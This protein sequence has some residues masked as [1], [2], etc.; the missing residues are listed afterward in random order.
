[1]ILHDHFQPSPPMPVDRASISTRIK[2]DPE[3]A[4][5]AT[6]DLLTLP[7]RFRSLVV[8][9]QNRVQRRQDRDVPVKVIHLESYGGIEL[10]VTRGVTWTVDKITF[11]P[12]KLVFGHN[13][14]ALTVEDFQKALSILL[15]Y[16]TVLLKDPAD[17]IHVIPG[18]SDDSGAWWSS[19]EIPFQVADPDGHLLQAFMNAKH[20]RIRKPALRCVGQ[21]ISWRSCTGDL[22]I[23]VYRKDIEMVA[24]KG[25]EGRGRRGRYRP[26]LADRG[27]PEGAG[28]A[29]R[30]PRTR[31]HQA[32][33]RCSE[34]GR[35]LLS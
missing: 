12:G 30:V 27:D 22:A 3:F 1:M 17:F 34:G 29:R 31:R 5:A 33:R 25:E 19:L 14:R 20:P 24:R 6:P 26:G 28:V 10:R 8:E 4:A 32:H 15:Q 7:P 23:K 9:V 2:L 35:L 16:V 18:I 11:N 21:S 13:G